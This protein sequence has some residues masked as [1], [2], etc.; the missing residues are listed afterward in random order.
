MDPSSEDRPPLLL[1]LDFLT[2]GPFRRALAEELVAA[3]SRRVSIPCRLLE[4][5][6]ESDESELPLLP[7]RSQVDSDFML[8]SVE[9]KQAARNAA[10]GTVLVGLTT[11]DLGTKVFSF[12]FGRA[13]HH[14][15]AALVSLARLR[16]EFYGL[17][18]DPKLTVRRAVAEILHEVG[19]TAGAGHCND[20]ACVM[21]FATNVESVDLR[22]SAF[23]PSCTAKLPPG[24]GVS[25][26]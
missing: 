11:Q 21:H 19:H 4:T 18:P 8:K 16:P 20:L 3:V 26:P 10:P 25:H 1:A 9:T 17:P 2:I 22:G 24:L 14:G 7:G 5:P 12:A 13:R 6:P 15:H 23:C